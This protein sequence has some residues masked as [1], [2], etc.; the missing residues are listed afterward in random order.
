MAVINIRGK[1]ADVDIFNE[2]QAFDWE[3][4]TWTESKLVACSPFR[5]DKQPSF[6]ISMETGGWA[7]SGS[8]GEMDSGNLA[9]LL[10]YM[11]GTDYEEASEYLLDKYGAMYAVTEEGTEI[12]LPKPRLNEN[13]RSHKLLGGGYVIQ[14]VSPYMVTRGIASDV[15][16]RFAIGYGEGH[17]G[18]TAIPWHTVGG[19]LANVKYRSTRG[20]KF[21]YE[22]GATPVTSLVYGIDQAKLYEDVVIVEGEVDALSW[23]TAGFPSIALGGAHLSREQAE[24]IIREGFRRVYAAGDNDGQGSKLNRKIAE[25]VGGFAEVFEV[26]Y[27]IEKDANDV[28]LSQGV[29]SMWDIIDNA[30]RINTFNPFDVSE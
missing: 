1:K 30:T 19:R 15:Q 13:I 12:K 25:G 7:D 4:G 2:L 10:G 3:R 29:D 9:K 11:R 18:F 24:T 8:L 16:E 6:F 17:R 28:L 23:W 27:G 26:D 14:A 22:K 20:K 5:E 21:F